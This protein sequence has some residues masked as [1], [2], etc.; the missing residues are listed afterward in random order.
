MKMKL[1]LLILSFCLISC[2]PSS[3][4]HPFKEDTPP[5]E[6]ST[7]PNDAIRF[8]NENGRYILPVI[9]NDSIS[10][11]L[12]L[13]N[14]VSNLILDSLFVSQNNKWLNLS[15]APKVIMVMNFPSSK[16]N[17]QVSTDTLKIETQSNE[18]IYKNFIACANMNN[19]N[20]RDQIAGIIPLK[21]FAK[22][23]IIFIDPQ[24][25]YLRLLDSIDTTGF[26]TIPFKLH[27][28]GAFLVNTEIYITTQDSIINIVGDF[29][30]DLGFPKSEIRFNLDRTGTIK[31]RFIQELE[32]FEKNSIPRSIRVLYADSVRVRDFNNFCLENVRCTF[33]QTN[34]K[35]LFCGIIGIDVLKHL[36]TVIDYKRGLI[37]FKAINSYF[38]NYHNVS[39]LKWGISLTPFPKTPNSNDTS[40]CIWLVT[41]LTKNSK[42]DSA[43]IKLW[44][45]LVFINNSPMDYP[46]K[47]GRK[48][49]GNA[50]SLTFNRDNRL[51]TLN[52]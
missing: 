43:N 9:L 24:Q 49:I 23:K 26:S 30:I 50:T 48:A 28:S 19:E 47:L 39:N 27:G 51:V 42:A 5:D 3:K 13:D 1:A 12:G 29:L 46:L 38:E 25:R 37:H 6:S 10:T 20:Y 14:G 32:S 45:E 21:L 2:I 22:H 35:E 17:S 18:I 7:I 16:K 34:K 4:N 8:D 33:T 36:I 15:F 31:Y 11:R 52:N 40:K 44:D 41:G